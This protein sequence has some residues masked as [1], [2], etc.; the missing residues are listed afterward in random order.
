MSHLVKSISSGE[1][2]SKSFK[3]ASSVSQSVFVIIKKL[4]ILGFVKSKEMVDEWKN[5]GNKKS[6]LIQIDLDL[7][8]KHSFFIFKGLSNIR[9]LFLL[10]SRSICIATTNDSNSTIRLL[11]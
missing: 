1:I 8:Y 10:L 9:L 11:N 3:L 2:I 6:L 4:N 7:F 5:Q